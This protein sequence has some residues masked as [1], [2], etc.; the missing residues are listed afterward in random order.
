MARVIPVLV[1]GMVYDEMDVI[2]LGGDE[3]DAHVPDKDEDIKPR[4]HRAK[5][6]EFEH[7]TTAVSGEDEWDSDYDEDDDDETTQW[8]LR[9]CSAAALDVISTVYGAAIL[10]C[11]LPNLNVNLQST[12]WKLQESAI[13]AL[14]AIAEGK[15][16]IFDTP[17]RYFECSLG[18]IEGMEPHLPQLLPFLIQSLRSAKVFIII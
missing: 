5:R 17:F 7:S 18:C 2:T 13:L 3:D 4:Q 12:D 10:E 14:G 8:N 9:K 11:L 16:Y 6:H 1:K 15:L